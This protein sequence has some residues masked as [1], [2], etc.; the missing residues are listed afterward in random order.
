MAGKGQIIQRKR[1]L[2]GNRQMAGRGAVSPCPRRLLRDLSSQRE[3]EDSPGL[4]NLKNQKN[5]K[6]FDPK[7]E[8]FDLVYPWKL[9]FSSYSFPFFNIIFKNYIK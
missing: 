1:K 3:P 8:R 9:A 7:F 4:Y 5:F 6:H 2:G